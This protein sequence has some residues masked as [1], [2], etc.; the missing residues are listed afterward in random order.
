MDKSTELE[1]VTVRRISRSLYFRIPVGFARVNQLKA[2][3]VVLLDPT[4]G[5]RII[6]QEDF[7]CLGRAAELEAA[8]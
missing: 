5:F 6:H 3:D 4:K 1:P 7:A 2:G 8:E